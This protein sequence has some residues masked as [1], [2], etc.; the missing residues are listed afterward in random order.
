MTFDR[1]LLLLIALVYLGLLAWATIRIVRDVRQST[2]GRSVVIML[3]A[4]LMLLYAAQST[5]RIDET[6]MSWILWPATLLAAALLSGPSR[7]AKRAEPKARAGRL[8][9][10]SL[11]V[12]A[13]ASL[14]LCTGIATYHARYLPPDIGA[15]ARRLTGN[16]RLLTGP[17]PRDQDLVVDGL[18]Q[19]AELIRANARLVPTRRGGM[20]ANRASN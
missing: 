17:F 19:A 11:W 13:A 1:G 18:R 8:P 16:A 10:Q 5:N 4:G 15:W 3:L 6:H 14:V 2:P 20:L 9:G 7:S 12:V